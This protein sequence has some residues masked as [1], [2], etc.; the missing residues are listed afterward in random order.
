M[1]KRRAT[2]A[3][4]AAGDRF[5]RSSDPGFSAR[6]TLQSGNR[7]SAPES[8]LRPKSGSA[9]ARPR[10]RYLDT[11]SSPRPASRRQ[12]PARHF[13]CAKVRR[14]DCIRP[15]PQWSECKWRRRNCGTP[16]SNLPADIR[17]CRKSG[18]HRAQCPSFHLACESR[19]SA[20]SFRWHPRCKCEDSHR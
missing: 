17:P 20:R 2:A 18:R 11:R 3:T 4:P 14:P 8:P 1:A 5:A 12:S 16:R 13:P 9:M 6:Q 19:G 15:L 10:E 7:E